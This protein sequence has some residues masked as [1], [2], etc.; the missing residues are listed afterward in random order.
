MKS[1]INKNINKYKSTNKQINQDA[2][3]QINHILESQESLELMRFNK[4][5]LTEVAAIPI[6]FEAAIVVIN[7]LSLIDSFKMRWC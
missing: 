1:K 7:S 4:E 5:V 2:I 6:A 3:N